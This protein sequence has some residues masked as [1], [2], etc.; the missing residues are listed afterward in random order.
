MTECIVKEGRFVVACKTLERSIHDVNMR[1]KSRGITRWD[2]TN[3]NTG[4][5]S[6][7]FFGV[8]SGDFTDKGL[9]FN[10]CPFCGAQIDAPLNIDPKVKTS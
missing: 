4:K 7:T 9:A 10:F 2:L 8:K 5:R 6:R 1:G 3:L